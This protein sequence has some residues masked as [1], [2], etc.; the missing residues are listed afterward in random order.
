MAIA[1]HPDDI[2]FMM[3]GTLMRLGQVG[4][5]L[6]YMNIANGCCGSLVHDAETTAAMRADEARRAAEIMGAQWYPPLTGD[7]E[8]FYNDDLLRQ[9][10]AVIRQVSPEILL[11]HSPVDYME[12]HMNAC[13][14]AVS[15][16]FARGMPNY[17]TNPPVSPVSQAVTLYH[18]MPHELVD[19]FGGPVN[20]SIFVNVGDLMDL[21][22]EALSAHASQKEWLDVSQGMDSYLKDMEKTTLEM[23]RQSGVFE[24]AE[25]WLPHAHMGFCDRSANPLKDA[26]GAFFSS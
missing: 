9:L 25:G 21:K 2:E 12:D 4:W 16:A 26:L 14:L 8:I 23:G 22:R 15:A 20:A 24:Y 7:L 13:R 17:Q 3:S 19:T 18:A 10:A 1:A 5:E 11:I 6:H